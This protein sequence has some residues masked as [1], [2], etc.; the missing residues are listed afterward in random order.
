[1]A[2]QRVPSAAR[3]SDVPQQQLDHRCRTDDLASERMLRPADRVDNRRNFLHVPVLADGCKHVGGLQ[4]LV[5]RDARDPLDGFRRV[6]RILLFQQ[7]EHTARMLEGQVV[8]DI[9]RKREWRGVLLWLATRVLY[10]P[11]PHPM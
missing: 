11:P 1:M 9:G 8:S 3:S 5:P 2:A 10:G 7:L 4:E 6:T